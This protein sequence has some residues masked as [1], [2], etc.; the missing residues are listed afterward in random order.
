M[1]VSRRKALFRICGGDLGSNE[2]DID[3]ASGPLQ[4]TRQ[5]SSSS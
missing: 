2:R 4:G 3:S 1:K 5:K